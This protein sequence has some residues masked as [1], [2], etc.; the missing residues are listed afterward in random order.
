MTMLRKTIGVFLL[1]LASTAALAQAPT[2]TKPNISTMGLT[3]CTVDQLLFGGGSVA[4]PVCSGSGTNG[5][6]MVGQTGAA[7]LFKTITGD[8]TF[9]AAGAAAL[10]NIP[11]DVP[12]AGDI[13]VTNIA[14][15]ATPAAGKVRVYGDSTAANLQMKNSS[16]TVATM[17][18]PLTCGGG[19]FA[20]SVS[21]SGVISCSTPAGGSTTGPTS[22]SLTTGTDATY[23]TPASVKW[24]EVAMVGA[25]GGSLGG[26]DTSA[27]TAPGVGGN[28]C[29]K[30]SGTACTTPLYQASGGGAATRSSVPAQGGAGGT[31][32]G[33][34]TCN[35]SSQ[36][37]GAGG[38]TGS[39]ASG[40]GGVGG[41]SR[42]GGAVPG[43]ASGGVAGPANSG[44]GASGGGAG[45]TAI[46]TGAGGGGGGYCYFIINNPAAT[47]VF[48]IGAGGTAGG[49]GT[50]GTAGAAG[51][52][53]KIFVREHYNF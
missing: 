30:A 4:T 16:G 53:G 22:Q 35:E 48:T 17:V 24:I 19:G 13:L 39:G 52:S 18:V 20:N 40:T 36:G 37:D 33:S 46:I 1:A 11:N 10:G 31:F 29:W 6:I 28:T 3:N 9:T 15:P 44:A 51:G 26:G 2:T 41:G 7:P 23:T 49:I 38:G 32:A 8:V 21:T 43:P 25:G 42:M 50:A 12:Q 45:N 34:A 14:A 27:A 47:Y 5:Q